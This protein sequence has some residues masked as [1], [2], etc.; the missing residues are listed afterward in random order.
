V[1]ED[2]APDA[3][4]GAVPDLT[5]PIPL[6]HGG[7][8]PRVGLGTWPMD[9]AD[10]E[11]AVV[12]A[13]EAG[14]RL[15]DTAYNYGNEV[16]VGRG[17]RRALDVTGLARE[18]IVVTTKFNAEWHGE[19]LSQDAYSGA[20]ER[21][22]LEY[23]D[24]FLIHWPNPW[25]DRYVDA[26][27]GLIALLE[28]GRVRAIGGSNF[29][30]AHLER[31]RVETGVEMDV[32]QR[33]I[34]PYST[35]EAERAYHHEHGIATQAWSPIGRGG[36][37]LADPVLVAIAE[38]VGRTVPQVVLRWHLQQGLSVA[39]KSGNPERIRQNIALFDFELTAEQMAAISGLDRGTEGLLDPD[40]FGH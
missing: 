19:Q 7:V 31:I 2:L 14:Y 4:A 18:D 24:L 35:R 21:M 13:I 5:A 32:N 37:L 1:T 39:P 11:V 34:S 16:G 3:V 27:R 26:W 23:I 25:Q 6:T 17:V 33:Q 22:G 40:T 30:P 10:S 12:T 28:A 8:L 29:T 9:D 38:Q 20:L 15:V 36:E